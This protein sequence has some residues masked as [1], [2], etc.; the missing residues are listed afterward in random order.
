MFSKSKLQYHR[1]NSIHEPYCNRNI[2]FLICIG[3][4]FIILYKAEKVILERLEKEKEEKINNAKFEM[5]LKADENQKLI[6][7]PVVDEN[8][9][10]LF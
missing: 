5:L 4:L 8:Q 1:K 10:K 9:T 6:P 2:I 7:R 3:F